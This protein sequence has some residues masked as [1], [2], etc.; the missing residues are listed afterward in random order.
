[1]ASKFNAK[2]GK[3]ASTEPSLF[4]LNYKTRR[5]LV[6]TPT[7]Y[8][9]LQLSIRRHFPEIPKNHRV[10]YHTN[11]LAVCEGALTEISSDIWGTVIPLLNSVTVLS[12]PRAESSTNGNKRSFQ[13][14]SEALRSSADE[15]N[16]PEPPAKKLRSHTLQ[17]QSK[18]PR[19][20]PAPTDLRDM[21]LFV[22]RPSGRTKVKCHHSMSI[23][24]ILSEI[25]L[26][27][28]YNDY[29]TLYDFRVTWDGSRLSKEECE[30]SS[31]ADLGIENG[32]V[33]EV[34]QE[35]RGGK[36]V[37]YLSPPTGTEVD[38][39]VKLSLV[40]EW[41]LSAI[42]P[43]VSIKSLSSRGQ[44]LQ[45]DVKASSDGTLL[46]KTTGL[47]VAYLFWEAEALVAFPVQDDQYNAVDAETFIPN[48]PRLDPMKSVLLE[49]ATMTPYLDNAL[50]A[51]G[52]HT[53][54]R[55]SFVTYI[56]IP[57]QALEL[58]SASFFRVIHLIITLTDYYCVDFD[59]R[60]EA[61]ANGQSRRLRFILR[62]RGASKPLVKKP[63]LKH[64]LS[65]QSSITGGPSTQ[66]NKILITLNVDTSNGGKFVFRCPLSISVSA[67]LRAIHDRLA[68]ASSDDDDEYKEDQWVAIWDSQ[69]LCAGDHRTIAA[70]GME[71]EDEIWMRKEHI[72]GKPVIYLLPPS[73]SEIGASVKLS[74]VPEWH[75]SAIYRIV[76]VDSLASG[77][78]TLQWDVMTSCDGRLL[79]KNTGLEVAYLFWEAKAL[80]LSTEVPP[81]CISPPAPGYITSDETFIPTH[82]R[83]EP[84]N[85]V[86]LEVAKVTPYLD[87]ALKTL[88]L[89]TEART[90][91]I[92]YWLPSFLRH[93]YIALRFLPQRAYEQAAPLEVS[94]TPDVVVRV[95]ML[96]KGLKLGDVSPTSTSGWNQGIRDADVGR[97]RRV[98]GVDDDRSLADDKLFRVIEWG[99]MEVLS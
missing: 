36:P 26:K 18:A 78:Q 27:S 91:F 3:S 19:S 15:S 24:D 17:A 99:G 28:R 51:L 73:G 22:G 55:T 87:S 29:F 69:R 25:P 97:W 50:K 23:H 90:S 43:V 67:L 66:A 93:T 44:S 48:Q 81:S 20:S 8:D 10:S 49:V 41:H 21:T 95:F 16:H 56:L 33:I 2:P 89:H 31:L 60:A 1:M 5:V 46:E 42:Y 92:T 7:S 79:E 52:L 59:Y 32:D 70:Y 39:T 9:Q 82:A 65:S 68:H 38:A 34:S 45:W 11:G 6:L 14:L 61:D 37:T 13:E 74:L 96:F 80:A 35:V 85:S 77:G 30:R 86:V 40:P 84:T 53:E 88:G 57:F 76:P 47:E 64:T 98:V 72:G 4:V 58:R 12:G 62:R 75:F 63:R 94:P 71:D 83:L 54:A